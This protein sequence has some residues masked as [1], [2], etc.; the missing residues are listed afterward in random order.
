MPLLVD[1]SNV[2][3]AQGALSPEFAGPSVDDLTRFIALSRFGRD[4]AW[5]VC[6]HHVSTL[7]SGGIIIEG[8]GACASADD[9]LME[10]LAESSAARRF[11][12]VTSDRA[13][14]TRARRFGAS[15]CASDEFL[16]MLEHDVRAAG[17][18]ARSPITPSPRA[19]VPLSRPQVSRWMKAFDLSDEL[20][21]LQSAA[22]LPRIDSKPLPKPITAMLE[23]TPREA[24][25]FAFLD[26]PSGDAILD[27]LASL[28][29]K[30]IEA[31]MERF[32]PPMPRETK[33]T[34]HKR[35]Q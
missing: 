1:A 27:A 14:A 4:L 35:K 7:R 2:L 33:P 24:D 15:I 30:S 21:A 26:A 23:A 17:T 10:V 28:D 3:L 6:D 22:A 25:L 13:L 32:Q 11:T 34:P 12:V 8:P 16:R 20:L 5:I 18:R 9:R 31:L 29:S 19:L